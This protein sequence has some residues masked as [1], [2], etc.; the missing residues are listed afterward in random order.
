MT[1]HQVQL[2]F[3]DIALILF[4][5]RGLGHLAVRIKQPPDR[6]SVV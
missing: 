1:S 5:A 2:L 4:L 6:K 3:V